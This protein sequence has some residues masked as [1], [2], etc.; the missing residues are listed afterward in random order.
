MQAEHGSIRFAF[1][2]I[3][4]SFF[5]YPL[6]VPKASFQSFEFVLADIYLNYFHSLNTSARY[7]FFLICKGKIAMSGHRRVLSRL[8][9]I[10]ISCKLPICAAVSV[11]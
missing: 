9:S 8:F 4:I 11:I 10:R 3:A 7:N 5:R 6:D 2:F 1:S